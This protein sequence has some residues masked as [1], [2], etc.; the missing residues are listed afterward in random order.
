MKDVLEVSVS[1]VRSEPILQQL[2][3]IFCVYTSRKRRKENSSLA[4]L[5]PLVKQWNDK[6]T[7]LNVTLVTR[8]L[9]SLDGAS[10]VTKLW[11]HWIV[12]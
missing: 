6:M 11:I 12:K 9:D 5:K 1:A 7:A 4:A 3:G 2:L 10:S 8:W